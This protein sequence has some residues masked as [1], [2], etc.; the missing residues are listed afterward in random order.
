MP[1][2]NVKLNNT[3]IS[4]VTKSQRRGAIA[5]TNNAIQNAK[6]AA[7]LAVSEAQ[8][9]FDRKSSV[10][11]LSKYNFNGRSR[12]GARTLFKV[13]PGNPLRQYK[14]PVNKNRQFPPVKRSQNKSQNR[15]TKRNRIRQSIRNRTRLG[16][17]F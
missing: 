8:S 16:T 15:N 2:E 4:T 12:R 3:S 5:S 14:S 1:N 13:I 17:N 11:P 6:L 7:N 9:E 10:E